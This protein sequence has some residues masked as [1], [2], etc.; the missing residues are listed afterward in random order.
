M[1]LELIWSRPTGQVHIA[2][3]LSQIPHALPHPQFLCS[4]LQ[5]ALLD[6]GR[7]LFPTLYG[8]FERGQRWQCRKSAVEKTPHHC[9]LF[10]R[11]ERQPYLCRWDQAVL[12]F[13]R[14]EPENG[15]DHTVSADGLLLSPGSEDYRIQCPAELRQQFENWLEETW[16]EEMRLLEAASDFGNLNE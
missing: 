8:E 9:L 16:M 13:P 7:R 2:V 15:E 3:T 6:L 5:T 12:F 10:D 4:L 1:P 14:I 11:Q